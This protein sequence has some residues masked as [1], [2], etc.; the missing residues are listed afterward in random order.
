MDERRIALGVATAKRMGTRPRWQERRRYQS[1][2]DPRTAN[3]LL[4]VGTEA[5]QAREPAVTA[6]TAVDLPPAGI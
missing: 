1:Y 6:R 2:E 3:G 4:T 5:L